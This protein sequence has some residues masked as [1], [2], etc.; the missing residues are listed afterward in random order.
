MSETIRVALVDD[1]PFVR[2]SLATILAAAGDL[3]ICGEGADGDEA[4]ALYRRVRPDILLLDIQMPGRDGI[5][6]ASEI[7]HSDPTARIVF[8]T[9]FSDD[10]YI[11]EALRLGSKGYLIK[12]EVANLA[13][14]LR[15]VMAGQVVL[16]GEVLGRVSSLAQSAPEEAGAS[17]EERA[18]ADGLTER[19]FEI[20]ERIAQGHDNKEIAAELF[21]SEGTVRNHVSVILAK[22][23]LKNRTQLARYYY[24][25]P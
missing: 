6:A 22:L 18:R 19:E 1:D 2:S 12:Q 23:N 10:A 20:V 24:Q 25:A 17:A 4:I 3:E 11:T 16:G 15:S 8:L 21:M 9:T 7:L 5:S 13:P 14:A